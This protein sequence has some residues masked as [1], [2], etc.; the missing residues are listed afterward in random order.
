MKFASRVRSKQQTVGTGWKTLLTDDDGNPGW[1]L[2]GPVK[3]Q[4]QANV[5]VDGLAAGEVLVLRFFTLDNKGNQNQRAYNWPVI[6]LVGTAG[7]S[8]GSIVQYGSIGS[9]SG[10]NRWLRL[11]ARTEQ[12]SVTVTRLQTSTFSQ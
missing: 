6:E 3:F 10:W 4:A 8:N 1:D 2:A 11:E 7:S 9:R 12:G 5:C